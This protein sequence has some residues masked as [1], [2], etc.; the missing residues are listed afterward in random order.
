MEM[1]I[2]AFDISFVKIF[3]HVFTISRNTLKT[4]DRSVESAKFQNQLEFAKM[5][6]NQQE[7]DNR[8]SED[9]TIS[10]ELLNTR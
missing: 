4:W 9:L 10:A 2:Y 8:S 5:T 3:C 7:M 1:K 6:K